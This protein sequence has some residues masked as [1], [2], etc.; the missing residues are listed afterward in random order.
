MGAKEIEE[1]ALYYFAEYGYERTSLSIIA[2]DIGIKKQSVYSH[3]KS[4]EDLFRCA[5]ERALAEEY[6][7]AKD[8]FSQEKD[9]FLLL[10]EFIMV[11][12]A[13]F[14]SP[15]YTGKKF[16]LRNSFMP[17]VSFKEEVLEKAVEYFNYLEDEVCRLFIQ[18]GYPEEEARQNAQ[19]YITILDG[20]M[21]GLVYGNEQ[22]FD[23]RLAA[24]WRLVQFK[25]TI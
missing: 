10:D 8:F 15:E 25:K 1:R 12:K 13:G 5:F 20:L 4:K 18:E 19:A 21:T 3:F 17:P 6:E 22:R 23:R 16:I 11:M 14:L 9:L 24:I 7:F 2:E